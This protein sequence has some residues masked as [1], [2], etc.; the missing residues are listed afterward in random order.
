MATTKEKRGNHEFFVWYYTE[1]DPSVRGL[2]R[3]QVFGKLSDEEI[4][5]YW[6][7]YNLQD[8]YNAYMAYIEEHSGEGFP[9]PKNLEDYY[10]NKDR[11]AEERAREEGEPSAP[12]QEQIGEYHNYLDYIKAHPDADLTTPFDIY[13]Y[14]EH[15]DE[16]APSWMEGEP[17]PWPEVPEPYY[18]DEEVRE[19]ATYQNYAS[20][21]GDPDDWHPVDIEDYFKNWDIAQEQLG[22][23]K[24]LD[25]TPEQ[26]REYQGYK[27]LA[28]YRE[29]GDWLAADI[30][31]FFTNYDQAK[32]QQNIWLGK[33]QIEEESKLSPEEQARRREESYARSQYAAQE[34]YHETPEY[35]QSF[36]NWFGAQGTKSQPL[37]SFIEGMFGKLQTQYQAG[38]PTLTGFPTREEARAEAEKREAGF[39]AWLPQQVPAVEEQF[40]AQSPRQR[41]EAPGTFAPRIRSVAF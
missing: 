7:L 33:Y 35:G 5:K 29:P 18:S 4:N 21:F 32:Q 41:W 31:D 12:T 27:D 22:E 6:D 16:W 1:I 20:R 37:Q 17:T 38:L 15:R 36:S 24:G 3:T 26:Q 39:E 28:S 30:E 25:Y 40:W 23:W 2:N 14:L 8:E 11:W 13:D 10:N 34:A 19:Y 9:I